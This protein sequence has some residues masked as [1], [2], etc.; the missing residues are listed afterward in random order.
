MY[1]LKSLSFLLVT[2]LLLGCNHSHKNKAPTSTDEKRKLEFGSL[3]GED[4]L[5]FGGSKRKA[6]VLTNS[7]INIYLWKASLKTLDFIP[8]AS[9]DAIG[10]VIVTEWYDVPSQA[11]KLKILIYVTSSILKSDAIKVVVHKKIKN[12]QGE[13][14]LTEPD[15][16]IAIELENIILTKARQLRVQKAK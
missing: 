3:I 15:K 5:T 9:I 6:D 12:S 10:G 4:F 13:W 7:A 2:V 14:T 1:F 16:S 8:L 11:E